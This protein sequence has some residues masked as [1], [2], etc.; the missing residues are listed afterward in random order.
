[1]QQLDL[2][3]DQA[4]AF[5]E[6]SLDSHCPPLKLSSGRWENGSSEKAD[7]GKLRT[8]TRHQPVPTWGILERTAFQGA[9]LKELRGPHL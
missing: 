5:T 7:K 9:V 3:L 2:P 8:G 1:M 4:K 6:E